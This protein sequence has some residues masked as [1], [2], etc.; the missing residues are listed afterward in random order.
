MRKII[1]KNDPDTIVTT[2]FRTH[3]QIWEKKTFPL[4]HAQEGIYDHS[5]LY[6]T[7]LYKTT[8][9]IVPDYVS[10]ILRMCIESEETRK[11]QKLSDTLHE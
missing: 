10:Y 9:N 4:K 7:K 6:A 5:E 8:D 3:H 11:L 2:E 1:C